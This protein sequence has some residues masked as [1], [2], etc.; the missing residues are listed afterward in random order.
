MRI[1]YLNWHPRIIFIK[2]ALSTPKLEVRKEDIADGFSIAPWPEGVSVSKVSRRSPAPRRS[3]FRPDQL[4]ASI[5]AV[6][7][8]KK[9]ESIQVFSDFISLTVG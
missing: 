8:S 3:R 7:G 1:R 4:H 2:I 5:G 6:E 9:Y